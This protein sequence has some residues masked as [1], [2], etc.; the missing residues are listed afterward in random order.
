MQC[1]Y[2]VEE[3]PEV[4]SAVSRSNSTDLRRGSIKGLS[5]FGDRTK[6]DGAEEQSK[7]T[8]F[9]PPKAIVTP[10]KRA[11]VDDADAPFPVS[12]ES[13]SPIDGRR[14]QS[15]AC[16]GGDILPSELQKSVS[17]ALLRRSSSYDLRTEKAHGTAAVSP[18]TPT[19]NSERAESPPRS[20]PAHGNRGLDDF[21]DAGGREEGEFKVGDR[22]VHLSHGEGTVVANSPEIHVRYDSGEVHHYSLRAAA[23]KLKSVQIDIEASGNDSSLNSGA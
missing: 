3:T 15:I 14:R 7:T 19:R 12:R 21:N 18:T 2:M 11:D 9:R 1:S 23:R 22:V 6:T 16:P 8:F 4:D 5:L 20:A 10:P 17:P 13:L